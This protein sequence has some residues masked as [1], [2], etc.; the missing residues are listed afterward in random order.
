MVRADSPDTAACR[1]VY[2]V[3]D[4][5]DLRR[6]L[7]EAIE[8]QGYDVVA[9]ANG[10]E[11]LEALR[12]DDKRPCLILLDL[13]MPV[14]NGY[15]FRKEQRADPALATIPVVVISAHERSGVD[16]DVFLPKPVA[17]RR[18]LA[19]IARYCK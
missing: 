18:L 12:R 10:A 15:E 7:G 13:M 5:S 11:A 4:D 3:E 1:R 14:M 6:T 16:A 9:A 17:L 8:A 2:V 19:V